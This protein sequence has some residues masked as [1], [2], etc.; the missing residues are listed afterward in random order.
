MPAPLFSGTSDEKDRDYELENTVGN[1]MVAEYQVK[2]LRDR[3]K[4]YNLLG[5]R[6]KKS[7]YIFKIGD[8]WCRVS[9][10]AEAYTIPGTE[11]EEP[12]AH[13]KVE[14]DEEFGLTTGFAP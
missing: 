1:L 6:N 7:E 10:T 4:T 12:K 9:I 14:D 13:V 11:K 5:F 8:E 3:L 2:K